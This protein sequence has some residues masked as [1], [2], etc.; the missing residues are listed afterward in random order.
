M[1]ALAAATCLVLASTGAQGEPKE[2]CLQR[3]S[4]H[5]DAGIAHHLSKSRTPH[6]VSAEG[7][8]CVAAEH[9]SALEEASRQVDAHF[10]EVARLLRDDCEER[11]FVEWA[12][13]EKLRF[14]IGNVVD[15]NRRP[16][17]RM[18]HL[19]SYSSDEVAANRRKLDEAP[20]GAACTAAG[21]TV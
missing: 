18:F 2:T 20:A 3:P 19:R 4:A 21:V 16:A 17:G 8:V 1:R 15:L 5:Y 11:A 12:T 6:R 14:E 9:A 7:G 13:R 10:W